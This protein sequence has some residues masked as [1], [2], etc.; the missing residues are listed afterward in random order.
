MIALRLLTSS[1]IR[2]EDARLVERGFQLTDSANSFRRVPA[3]PFT[4]VDVSKM[5]RDWLIFEFQ[6]VSYVDGVESRFAARG[7]NAR[8]T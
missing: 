1:P 6:G 4:L 2:S 3:A 7:Q 8:A 5:E